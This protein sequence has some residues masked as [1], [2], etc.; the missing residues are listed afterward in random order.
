MAVKCA[1]KKKPACFCDDSTD[2]PVAA[3]CFAYHVRF[4]ELEVMA[5]TTA[6][7][8]MRRWWKRFW[9]EHPTP[10]RGA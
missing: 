6:Q 10:E 8:I 9:R 5:E 7:K 4:G 1:L 2:V 3:D